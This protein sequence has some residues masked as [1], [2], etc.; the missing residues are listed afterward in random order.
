MKVKHLGLAAA[1]AMAMSLS[2]PMGT[3]L[4]ATTSEAL[5][6][7]SL[8]SAADVA[9]LVSF[10]T[11]NPSL[12]NSSPVLLDFLANPTLDTLSSVEFSAFSDALSTAIDNAIY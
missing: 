6:L 11:A 3:A 2:A 1:A 9:G 12:A 7:Q 10:L 8:I 5:E 4:T